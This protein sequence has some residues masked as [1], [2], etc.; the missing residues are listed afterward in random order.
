MLAYQ[1]TTRRNTEVV[2][3]VRFKIV[4]LVFQQFES[5]TPHKRYS[6]NGST[7]CPEPPLWPISHLYRIMMPWES[8]RIYRAWDAECAS[9]TS[10]N[11]VSIVRW[12]C[13]IMVVWSA[14]NRLISVRIW[15]FPWPHWSSLVNDAGL[16]TRKS[17]VRIAHG[18]CANFV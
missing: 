7:D 8:G 18:V 15:L 1:K 10:S 13:S 12:E 6:Y 17:R 14:P 5:A 16:S 2:K 9:T 11:L 3:R 4:Y